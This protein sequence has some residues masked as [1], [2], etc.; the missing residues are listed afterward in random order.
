MSIKTRIVGVVTAATLIAS[1]GLVAGPA[2]AGDDFMPC[3]VDCGPGD[4]EPPDWGPDDFQTC[5]ED[6]SSDPDATDTDGVDEADPAQP[7]PADPNFT[8]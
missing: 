4:P 2:G 3:Q 1:L 5:T 7:R 8:G 6:C